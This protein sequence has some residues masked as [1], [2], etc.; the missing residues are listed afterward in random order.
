MAKAHDNR[1]ENGAATETGSIETETSRLCAQLVIQR[2]RKLPYECGE[3]CS[4][5]ARDSFGRDHGDR[6]EATAL[7]ESGDETNW[8]DDPNVEKIVYARAFQA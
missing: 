1:R 7:R 2:K 6:D 3:E 5:A 4:R 8:K